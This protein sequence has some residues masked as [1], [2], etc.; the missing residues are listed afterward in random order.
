MLFRS[1]A[2]TSNASSIIKNSGKVI[3]ELVF[4]IIATF[5]LTLDFDGCKE[6]LLR[7]VPNSIKEHAKTFAS[8]TIQALGR[9]IRA[10]ISIM[11]VTFIELF[12]GLMIFRVR[13]AAI[14]ALATT[15]IDIIPILGVGTV[16]IP[17]ALICFIIGNPTLGIE[18]LV[19]YGIIYVVRQVIEPKLVGSFVGIHPIVALIFVFFGFLNFGIGGMILAPIIAYVI[20]ITIQK[21]DGQDLK[22]TEKRNKLFK[23]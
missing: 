22:T 9:Y 20:Q 4:C 3:A 15:I 6:G 14:I 1:Q 16:L 13:Y 8:T 17:W 10:Y 19:L 18:L 21:Y 23:K 12:V 11:C 5:Y 7:L 2:I